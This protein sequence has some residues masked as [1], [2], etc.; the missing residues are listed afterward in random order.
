MTAE[1]VNVFAT[2]G[3]FIVIT[4]T[5]IAALIQLRHMRASNQL[6]AL[7]ALTD[8]WNDKELQRSVTYV[9]EELP[10]R[11]TSPEYARSLR[12]SAHDHI[13]H[14]ELALCSWWEQVGGLIK[15]RLVPRAAFLEL[16]SENVSAHWDS[17][18]ATITIVRTIR[19]PATYAN[20]EYV[21]FLGKQWLKDH[22]VG[23]YPSGAS[24]LAA[25]TPPRSVGAP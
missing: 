5:A 6:Q 24:R 21:A 10:K 8:R 3:T 12:S 11:L 20:F 18:A 19:G 16:S 15:F 25:P 1:T 4:V 2:V 7:L 22:P 14:P 13:N 9:L 23:D 17:L